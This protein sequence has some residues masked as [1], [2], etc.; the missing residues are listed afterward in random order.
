MYLNINDYNTKISKFKT[1]I[2]LT[3]I[4]SIYDIMLHKIKS[5]FYELIQWHIILEEG[6][7]FLLNIPICYTSTR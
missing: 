3:G 1:C 7:M 5:Q 4:N 2:L 6:N